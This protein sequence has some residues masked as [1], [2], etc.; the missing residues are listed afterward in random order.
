MPGIV[1]PG[2][3]FPASNS[4]S[5]M[6]SI[7]RFHIIAASVF[8]F[9]ATVMTFVNSVNASF[10]NW[11]DDV[12]VTE[13]PHVQSLSSE[14]IRWVF[15][16]SYYY[17]WLPL[18]LSSHSLDVALFGLRPQGHH[19]TNVF[20][21]AVNAVLFFLVSLILIIAAKR[22]GRSDRGNE[23]LSSS[24]FVGSVIAALLFAMHP[25]RV[26]SVAWVSGR[27]DLLC[28]IFLLPSFGLY[29]LWK[30]GG[31]K[32]YLFVSV[33]L[34]VLAILSK[35]MAMPFP[36][37]LILTD[38]WLIRRR[39]ESRL[40]L[41]SLFIDK[42]P[43]I[44]IA[45]AAAVITVRAA[46]GG[47]GNVIGEL[48]MIERL[49][50]PGYM[51][52]FYAVKLLVP[53]DLSPIY[54]ELNRTILYISPL[55]LIAG[56]YGCILLLKKRYGVV[57]LAVLSYVLILLPTFLGLSSGLQPLA[58]RYT[59]LSTL[60]IFFLGGG[61]VE[62]LWRRS[63]LSRGKKYQRE[64]FIFLLLIVCAASS[65]RTIR[66]IAIWRN[67]VSLW[68]QALLYAPSTRA[69]FEE[70]KPYM[71]PDY[72]DA[73]VNLGV[74]Y[75]E[76]NNQDKALEQFDKALRL[77]SCRASVHDNRGIVLYEKGET[78]LAMASFRRAIACDPGYAKA[79]YNLAILQSNAGNI[80]AAVESMQKSAR[81]GYPD[82]Q[83]AL[84][85][86]GYGW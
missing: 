84:K 53:T 40:S 10:V 54:P 52:V 79:Y 65:Y 66:H 51:V 50:L 73:H 83:S 28:A 15:S 85:S 12:Y 8:I 24:I 56:A 13:N 69:E 62:I 61:A 39:D 37:I 33:L 46:S 20:L 80:P 71:K 5:L 16:H 7:S 47:S 19:F 45:V 35:P 82:A 49:L 77:D 2:R 44:L 11:D 36:L 81:L 9:V 76:A 64:M 30:I 21:H 6:I 78:E 48:S 1:L 74:A 34:Y 14:N 43:F 55:V 3:I 67:S 58:D 68:T 4:H 22:A 17:S 70:R 60:S 57:V 27:K 32:R 25:L 29:L 42:L 75:L 63:S 38:V 72:V 23:P 26:E 31:R 18:T 41:S 59:Y 86:R